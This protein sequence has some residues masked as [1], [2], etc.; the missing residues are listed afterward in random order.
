MNS[1][2]YARASIPQFGQVTTDRVVAS[3]R[4]RAQGDEFR[5]NVH[6]GGRAEPVTLDAAQEQAAVR[7]AQ[8]LGLHIA[9]VDMLE[10]ADGPKIVEVN[11]SPGIEGIETATKKD[12]A[13]EIV[14]FV[15]DNVEYPEF[16]IRS[17]LTVSKGYGVADV[18]VG[19]TSGLVGKTLATSGLRDLDITVLSLS[20]EGKVIPN[21]R[22]ARELQ[23]GDR[24]VCY[25]RMANMKNLLPPKIQQRRRRKLK[26]HPPIRGG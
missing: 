16:D 1:R 5:S 11:S 19:E 21:P 18:V 7:A 24:L 2:P 10:G 12:V 6:R 15:R 17:R 14:D 13:G 23:V 3:M 9:G 8:I 20:R 4:R 22:G 25:G 26:P